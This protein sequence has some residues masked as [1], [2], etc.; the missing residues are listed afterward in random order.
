LINGIILERGK[1]KNKMVTRKTTLKS[2][3][4]KK[5]PKTREVYVVKSNHG[6]GWDDVSQENTYM[7]GKIRT[8]EYRENEKNASHKLITRRVPY[9]S[10]PARDVKS[11]RKEVIAYMLKQRKAR[12]RRLNK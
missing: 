12:A 8:R 5:H 1:R 4:K 2:K 11:D 6:Y 10:V 9:F 3:I 7:N